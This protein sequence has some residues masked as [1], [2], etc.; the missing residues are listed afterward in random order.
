MKLLC[1]LAV[2]SAPALEAGALSPARPPDEIDGKVLDDLGAP[3]TT[4]F[5]VEVLPARPGNP[6][7]L[8]IPIRRRFKSDNGTFHLTGIA[9]GEWQ[10]TA[11]GRGDVRSAPVFVTVPLKGKGTRIGAPEGSNGQ[12]NRVGARRGAYGRCRDLH[13]IR[14]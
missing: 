6:F 1:V 2:A 12:G 8:R 9:Q 10:L 14:R 7:E 13:P 4:R 3:T 5:W 11:Y